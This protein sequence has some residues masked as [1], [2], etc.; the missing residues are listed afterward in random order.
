MQVFELNSWH[1]SC[2]NPGVGMIPATVP[3]LIPSY[4]LYLHRNVHVE[5]VI[6]KP[7]LVY[8]RGICSVLCL[9]ISEAETSLDYD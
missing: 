7:K 1:A 5:L 8:L 3:Q 4:R 2:T 6:P 9:D